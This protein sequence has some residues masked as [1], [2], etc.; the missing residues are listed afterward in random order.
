MVKR[1]KNKHSQ[2]KV[3]RQL[4][5]KKKQKKPKRVKK[6]IPL[7]TQEEREK[8]INDIKLEISM[9]GLGPE[10]PGIKEAYEMFDQYINDGLYNEGKIKLEG[11]KRVLLF[12]LFSKTMSKCTAML[13]YNPDV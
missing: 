2:P 11:T 5:Q 8:E 13:Q 4:R 10:I 12:V 9:V 7:K 3:S 6:V 1:K